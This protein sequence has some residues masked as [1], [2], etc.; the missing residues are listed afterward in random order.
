[1]RK[2]VWQ[3]RVTIGVLKFHRELEP[4]AMPGNR[5][6][7]TETDGKTGMTCRESSDPQGVPAASE[8]EEFA[9]D[10]LNCVGKQSDINTGA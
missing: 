1:V 9:P 10:G 3:Q 7:Q 8:N 5:H 4:V 6:T 2:G